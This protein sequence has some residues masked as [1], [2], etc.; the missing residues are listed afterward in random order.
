LRAHGDELIA[1]C[2]SARHPLITE[3][4]DVE[5][6][7]RAVRE[8]QLGIGDSYSWDRVNSSLA[9]VVWL[10]RLTSDS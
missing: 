10:E 8:A 2:R 7:C 4:F 1:R 6:L 5:T 9:L 3:M